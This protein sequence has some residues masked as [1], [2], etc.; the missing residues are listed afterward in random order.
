MC[1]PGLGFVAV[2]AAAMRVCKANPAPRFYWDW[3]RRQG[4]MA[5]QKFCGTPP[6][7]LLAG[8]QAAL[9]LIAD[10]GLPQVLAR[11]RV[12]AGA[13][14]AA[15]AGWAEGGALDFFCVAPERR[16][17]AVTTITVPA[18]FDVDGFRSIA[19]ERFQVAVA[20]GLGPL[21]GRA[22]RIG[23]LGYQNAASIVGALGGVEAALRVMGVPVGAGGVQRAVVALSSG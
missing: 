23:H 1:P 9:G 19:R 6:Q 17:A 4:P 11:H 2:D 22:F 18:G 10:E 7:N 16:S 15:V 21:Q 20:G 14:H 8:L 12:L 13:V 3:V 5:Y